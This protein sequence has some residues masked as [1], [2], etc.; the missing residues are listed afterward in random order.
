[1][2]MDCLHVPRCTLYRF[3]AATYLIQSNQTKRYNSNQSSFNPH[4]VRALY[5]I[6]AKEYFRTCTFTRFV[7][8]ITI[9]RFAYSLNKV[10]FM[11]VLFIIMFFF[12]L[13]MMSR[14]CMSYEA[15]NSRISHKLCICSAYCVCVCGVGA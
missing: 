2:K 3:Y 12:L 14:E 10:L 15:Y 1:M 11:C 8:K 13:R 5:C 6:C 9:I 7:C 4:R